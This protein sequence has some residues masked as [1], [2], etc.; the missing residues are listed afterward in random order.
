MK[1]VPDEEMSVLFLALLERMNVEVIQY[2]KHYEHVSFIWAQ[3]VAFLAAQSRAATS[4]A[5]PSP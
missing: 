5:T 2:I 4:A 3:A 1:N